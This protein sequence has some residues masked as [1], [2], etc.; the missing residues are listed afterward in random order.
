MCVC[1]FCFGTCGGRVGRESRV[2]NSNRAGTLEGGGDEFRKG[3][4]VTWQR[5][6]WSI[7]EALTNYWVN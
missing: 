2:V 1:E 3:K 6:L 7:V 5:L 4:V